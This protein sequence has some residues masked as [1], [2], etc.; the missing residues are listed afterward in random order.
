MFQASLKGLLP[1][2]VDDGERPMIR[3]RIALQYAA[4]EPLMPELERV[5]NAVLAA[6]K[7]FNQGQDEAGQL[8][9]DLEVPLLG[10]EGRLDSLGLVTLVV[11]VE[12]ALADEFGRALTLADEKALSQKHSPFRTL[13]TLA[14]YAHGLLENPAP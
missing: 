14:A 13:R 5:E 3:G 1:A 12:Q 6:L 7:D 2:T 10:R 9:R 11:A 8:P 4:K